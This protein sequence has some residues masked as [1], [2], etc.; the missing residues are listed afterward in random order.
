MYSF[1]VPLWFVLQT[2]KHKLNH[3]KRPMNA[4]MVWSQL[5]RRKIIEVTPDKHNAEISKELGRRWKLLSEEARQTYIAEAERL[6]ILH[7]REYPNYKY[8][9]RKKPKTA[10]SGAQCQTPPTVVTLTGGN[11]AQSQIAICNNKPQTQ[12]QQPQIKQQQTGPANSCNNL[13]RPQAA[14]AEIVFSAAKKLQQDNI[15][16]LH[17][18]SDRSKQITRARI[19]AHKQPQQQQPIVKTQ[20]VRELVWNEVSKPA[21]PKLIAIPPHLDVNKLKLKLCTVT[22]QQ[23]TTADTKSSHG[24]EMTTTLVSQDHPV[25]IKGENTLFQFSTTPELTV[26]RRQ[27]RPEVAVAAKTP[28]TQSP[29]S[30]SDQFK[31]VIFTR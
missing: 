31:T 7:Q 11:S 27:K 16:A 5:E 2:K 9:P 14:A 10:G 1:V 12:T 13:I 28:R 21:G 17:Q 6:R 3:I 4:F 29:D 18:V 19:A 25:I 24:T 15:K 26:A 30:S 8:K 22:Q 23:T 20:A